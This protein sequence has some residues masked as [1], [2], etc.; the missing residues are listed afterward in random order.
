MLPEG[1]AKILFFQRTAGVDW[2][3]WWRE[4][5]KIEEMTGGVGR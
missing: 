4:G 1:M 3:Q 2:L 5:N